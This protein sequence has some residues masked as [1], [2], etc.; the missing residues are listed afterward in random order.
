MQIWRLLVALS[1]I[2]ICAGCDQGA[3]PGSDPDPV[4][5]AEPVQKIKM[6][7][8]I[9]VSSGCQTPTV[10]LVEKLAKEHADLVDLEMVDFGSPEG[11]QRWK[12][13]GLE[14]M[15]ILF[16]SG[17]GPSPALRF[18]QDDGEKGTVV[19]F[20]PAGFSWT[21]DDLI[22]AFAALKNGQLEILTEDEAR[23]ELAPEPVDAKVRV[24]DIDGAG[25]VLLNETP[26][27]TVKADSEDMGALERA[28]AAAAGI[29][30][31]V[32]EPVHPSQ[33]SLAPQDDSM[34]IFA[35]KS[36]IIEVTQA[37]AKAAGV[38]Q[39]KKLANEWLRAIKVSIID[40]VRAA[41]READA[42]G[43]DQPAEA[44]EPGA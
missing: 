2:A 43:E 36:E 7:A 16:D 8:Y 6:T 40:A 32:E 5:P 15:A 9:N 28:Q 17:D 30:E 25:Q 33:L 35:G 38:K 19:F 26:L 29:R 11:M 44:E 39:P 3:T 10:E 31:W 34:K 21:H 4:T 18:P 42:E 13:D 24:R 12:S 14:C 27:F 1:I 20:M 22:A 23:K 37:D 41:Q